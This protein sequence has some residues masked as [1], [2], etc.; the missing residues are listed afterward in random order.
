MASEPSLSLR[1]LA[2][3]GPWRRI[4]VTSRGD[5][6]AV[7]IRPAAAADGRAVAVVLAADA[8]SVEP[9]DGA[10]TLTL[11]LPLL[12]ERKSPKWTERLARCLADGPSTPADEALLD[13][14]ARQA[15]HDVGAALDAWAELS[16][17][18][19]RAALLAAGPGVWVAARLAG[20]EP[21]IVAFV[22][23]PAGVARSLDPGTSLSGSDRPCTT[24]ATVAEGRTRL[25]EALADLAR[26]AQPAGR[27]R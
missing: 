2:D 20:A 27:G 11:D 23:A 9:L 24:V 26:T 19:P 25:G 1:R 16:G 15:A 8:A 4:E 22:L 3:D 7:R 12:G 6:V 18:A 5:R 14:F 13:D 17:H 21:R 10:A